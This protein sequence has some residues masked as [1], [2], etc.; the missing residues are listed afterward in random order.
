MREIGPTLSSDDRSIALSASSLSCADFASPILESLSLQKG[1]YSRNL[2]A[3]FLK[4]KKLNDSVPRR[5]GLKGR[6]VRQC[7]NRGCLARGFSLGKLVRVCGIEKP[8][9]LSV[10][11]VDDSRKTT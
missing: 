4:F 9:L 10:K 1:G 7:R 5:A 11:A 6:G 8:R 2:Q 3:G